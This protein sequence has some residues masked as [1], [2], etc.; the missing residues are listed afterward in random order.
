MTINFYKTTEKYGCFSNFSSHEVVIWDMIWT[1]SEHAFQAAKFKD[2]K[3]DFVE[4]W[5]AATPRLAADMGR[6]RSRPLRKD[7]EQV[8]D[9]IMYDIVLAK[10]SQHEDIRQLLL[11]TGE[12][13]LVE[14][15][16]NDSY[17]G[18]GGDGTG[19]NML[20]KTLMRVRSVL[21]SK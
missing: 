9:E 15:T 19:K 21:T 16:K 14:H 2:S 7:W 3:D 6:D 4:V 20:G 8:K 10:F 18:D 13:I 11:S 17:W 1:T 12:D 5:R